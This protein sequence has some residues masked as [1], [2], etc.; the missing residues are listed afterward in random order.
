MAERVVAWKE[1][2]ALRARE[3]RRCTA[4]RSV[5][6]L[7]VGLHRESRCRQRSLQLLA[8]ISLSLTPGFL[9][10]CQQ[11][12]SGLRLPKLCIGGMRISTL[13]VFYFLTNSVLNLWSLVS[14]FLPSLWLPVLGSTRLCPQLGYP[15][16]SR[17]CIYQDKSIV[18]M[19]Q[20]A[21][22]FAVF[23]LLLIF[24]PSVHPSILFQKCISITGLQ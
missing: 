20:A 17:D 18:C 21:S 9:N 6:T 16:A 1:R 19:K 11:W 22:S 15:E 2:V 13:F 3:R 5:V 4:A 12:Q 24:H 7:R 14:S 10:G 23:L 8:F